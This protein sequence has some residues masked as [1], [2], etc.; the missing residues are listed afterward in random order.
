VVHLKDPSLPWGLEVH[1][2]TGVAVA[3]GEG[4]RHEQD[5]SLVC[6]DLGDDDRMGY[7]H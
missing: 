6:G 1:R 2:K 5:Q 3:V 7:D 4:S